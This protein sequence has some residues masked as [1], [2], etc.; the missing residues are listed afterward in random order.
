M[1]P[2]ERMVLTCGQ[3]CRCRTNDVAHLSLGS[4][5]GGRGCLPGASPG[6]STWTASSSGS[7]RGM[8]RKWGSPVPGPGKIRGEGE[9]PPE[10]P[11]PTPPPTCQTRLSSVSRNNKIQ[12]SFARKL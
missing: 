12:V 8:R 5:G 9:E 1:G 6:L 11:D 4:Q 10:I 7:Q 2:P 3:G